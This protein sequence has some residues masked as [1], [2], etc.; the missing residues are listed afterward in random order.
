MP[1]KIYDVPTGD[2]LIIAKTIALDEFGGT[3]TSLFGWEF[4]FALKAS[5]DDALPLQLLT[6]GTGITVLGRQVRVRLSAAQLAALALNVSYSFTLKA[7]SP[8]G[9]QTLENGL[10]VRQPSVLGTWPTMG[11]STQVALADNDGSVLVDNDGTVLADNDAGGG[12]P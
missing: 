1:F 6:L 3:V 10:L 11:G 2:D 8:N 12:A 4:A 9:I 7:R 5:V